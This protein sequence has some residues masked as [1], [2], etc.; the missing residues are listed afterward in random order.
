MRSQCRPATHS[1]VE[2]RI[3]AQADHRFRCKPITDSGASRSLIPVE[4]DHR[5]RSQADHFSAGTGIVRFVR[6][7]GVHDAGYPL[8]M[9]SSRLFQ[10]GDVNGF[11][12]V[13]H[14]QDSHHPAAVLR[15][16]AVDSGHRPHPASL[17]GGPRESGDGR[18]PAPRQGGG[19][20]LAVAR[21]DGRAHAR[22]AAVP[23]R[24]CAG[25][26]AACDAGLGAR[27]HRAAAQG[28]HLVAAV[29][30]VQGRASR[31][32]SVQPVLRA[33]PRLPPRG[34]CGHAPVSPRRREAVRG[35][36]RPHGAHRGP[37][38]RGATPSAGVRGRARGVELHLC[39]GH[40]DAGIA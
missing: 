24:R 2:L 21:G 5:F 32:D 40:L 35:L 39:R 26:G 17:T 30:G 31:W 12:E 23:R 7:E 28:G 16:R 9:T 3:P 6:C 4:P 38:E 8:A 34:R 33:L 11:Q 10:R 19:A 29:A 18:L 36:R 15:G 20:E 22:S 37:R 27:S 13:I 14:A 25:A 1:W